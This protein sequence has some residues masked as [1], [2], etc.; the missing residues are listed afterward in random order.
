MSPHWQS[1]LGNIDLP[2]K[3]TRCLI[4]HHDPRNG[5]ENSGNLW[6]GPRSFGFK[7]STGTKAG[8]APDFSEL[9]SVCSQLILRMWKN[10]LRFCLR[11][12]LGCG[13]GRMVLGVETWGRSSK[14]PLMNTCSCKFDKHF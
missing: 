3:A 8:V 11:V 9:P 6:L 13:L 10:V 4:L 12:T 5:D 7:N 1:D 14:C 2:G